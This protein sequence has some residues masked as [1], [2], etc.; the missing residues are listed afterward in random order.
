MPIVMKLGDSSVALASIAFLG[1]NLRIRWSARQTTGGTAFE[2]TTTL[3]DGTVLHLLPEV[4]TQDGTTASI[5]LRR[6]SSDSV[7]LLA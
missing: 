2:T 3:S 1:I 6:Q 7:C 5:N 4:P